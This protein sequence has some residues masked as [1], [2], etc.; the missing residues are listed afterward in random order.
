MTIMKKYIEPEVAV[1]ALALESGP[2]CQSFSAAFTEILTEDPEE[3][4]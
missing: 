2:I 3:E 1:I 4:I